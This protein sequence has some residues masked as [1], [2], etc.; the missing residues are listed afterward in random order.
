MSI[1]NKFIIA[2]LSMIVILVSSLTYNSIVEQNEILQNQL[3][4]RI[5]L[6]R[7]NI[8]TNAKHTV[9][10]LKADVE[11]DLASFNLSHINQQFT[12][13][14]KNQNIKAIV[15]VDTT[16]H[17]QLYKGDKTLIKHISAKT[18][19]IENTTDHITIHTP[20]TLS[21]R[22]GT[23]SVSY[24]LEKLQEETQK[25]QK[26][27]DQKMQESI[28]NALFTS[29]IITIIFIILSYFFSKRLTDPI[30]LLTDTAKDIANGDL[31]QANKKLSLIESEDEVGLLSKTFLQMTDQLEK[32]YKKL[33][34]LNENL[35]QK[36]HDR[37]IELLDAKVVAEE[38]TKVKSEFLANMSHEIRTPMNGIIGMSH[39]VLQTDLS[40][41]QKN[42]ITNID[43]S[44]KLLLNIINDILDFSKIEA[45]QLKIEKVNF[46]LFT[47]VDNVINIIEL[48]ANNKNL[49]LIVSYASNIGKQFSGDPLRIF[50]ILTNLLDNAVKFTNA[51]EVALYLSK[52]ENNR[53]R[54]EVKDTGIGL[55]Q[56][57]QEK[58]FQSFS[59]ADASIT[60]EYGG[61]GLGL[62]ISKQ[63]IE[64][65]DGKIWVESRLHKGSSFIFEIELEEIVSETRVYN[66][67]HQKRV[68]LVDDNQTWNEILVNLLDTCG[69]SVDVANSGYEALTILQSVPQNTYDLILMDWNMPKLDGIETT[70]LIN[71]TFGDKHPPTVIMISA[72]KQDSIEKLAKD[73]GVEMFLQK[74]INPS[75]LNDIL[76]T[77]FLNEIKINYT[78][79]QDNKSLLNDIKTLS[80]SRIL[81]V[82]DNHINQEIVLGLLED[83]DIIIDVANNGREAVDRFEVDKYEL[84]L[85][86][87]QMPVMD[88]FKATKLIRTQ[89]KEIP[90]IAITANAMKKD[91]QMT[92]KA[93]MNDH[94]SKPIEVNRLYEVLV[95]FI[96]KKEVNENIIEQN[97][98]EDVVIPHFRYIDTDLGLSHL[99]GNKKLYLKILNDFLDNFEG[100]DLEKLEKEKFEITIHTL[101]G[102][103]ASIGATKLNVVVTKLN[104]TYSKELIIEFNQEMGAVLKELTSK[105]TK[106]D[107]KTKTIQTKTIS[108]KEI[109]TLFKAL[110]DAIKSSRPKKCK[111]VL[112]KFEGYT[113][114]QDQDEIFTQI[115]HYLD[116]YKYKEALALLETR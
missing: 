51:G 116:K 49:E 22:W 97:S 114:P 115:K 54:F 32:S 26:L 16:G 66:D 82:E 50:Q 102:L 52:I 73:A 40:Q 15:L 101:K 70:K 13:Y 112:E 43:N 86:D 72:F 63:L 41:K 39:L 110:G 7:N 90:I 77:V 75:V 3:E 74:P 30:L 5:G 80:N 84:I 28:S 38:A 95:K 64:L 109:D 76:N 20:I 19:T 107:K 11:N 24:G 100:V 33:Q 21:K 31:T 111:D 67:F 17:M 98:C 57:Q 25:A 23:L 94:L 36:V 9:E 59:Q 71:T 42:Y 1:A 10:K 18:L 83:S 27:I 96:S 91:L 85:M 53:V 60:R 106:S 45:G 6:I 44:A 89:D 14:I 48:K 79:K 56:E 37:T 104:K 35:E 103:S 61:T 2:I 113:L 8:I 29:T 92:H 78:S 4:Q 93:G 62:S 47:V 105:L 99:A 12:Q 34:L 81:L 88:G 69:L 87:L 46:D 108:D 55:T 58:L 68:L 65:M